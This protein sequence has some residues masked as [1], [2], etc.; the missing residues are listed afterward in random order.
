MCRFQTDR[1]EGDGGRAVP[2]SLVSGDINRLQFSDDFSRAVSL[3]VGNQ[4][5]DF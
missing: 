3:N 4:P 5:C 1:L 2:G